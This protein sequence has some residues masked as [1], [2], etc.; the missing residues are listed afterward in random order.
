MVGYEYECAT[1]GCGVIDT[2]GLDVATSHSV[3]MSMDVK[4]DPMH[5][6]HDYEE[7]VVE[8]NGSCKAAELYLDRTIGDPVTTG[9]LI[10][11][12]TEGGRNGMT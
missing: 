12:G 8:K 10:D 9:E 3:V 4:H 5:A 7:A 11:R 2:K 1:R 6:P